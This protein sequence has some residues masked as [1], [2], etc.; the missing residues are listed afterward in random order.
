MEKII[1]M[2]EFGGLINQQGQAIRKGK[3]F[4]SGNP[5]VASTADIEQLKKL[6]LSEIIDFRSLAEKRATEPHFAAQFKWI[7]QPIFTGDLSEL[8]SSSLDRAKAVSHMRDI[9]KKFVIGFQQQ[10]H[11]LLKQAEQGKTLLYHCTAGKDRTGFASYLLLSALGVADE[12]IMKDYLL[13]N[14]SMDELRHQLDDFIAD[15]SVDD[16]ALKA[17]LEVNISYLESAIVIINQQYGGVES[18]LKHTLGI[19]IK[20]LRSHYLEG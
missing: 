7:A 13:S 5:S 19:D 20:A 12:L 9:Y 11:Y 10:F 8:L 15:G 6:N 17:I 1:N 2:R 18:Y 3:L 14:Q 4:R 16:D